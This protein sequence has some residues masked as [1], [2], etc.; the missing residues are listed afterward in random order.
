MVYTA[1]KYGDSG[2]VSFFIPTLLLLKGRKSC[3]VFSDKHHLHH[4]DSGHCGPSTLSK[5]WSAPSV[6]SH[7][8]MLRYICIHMHTLDPKHLHS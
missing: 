7:V 5:L 2:M 4:D 1:Y 8:A 6:P 3:S